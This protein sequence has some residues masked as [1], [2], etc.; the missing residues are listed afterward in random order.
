MAVSKEKAHI[1][2]PTAVPTSV[3]LTQARWAGE[4]VVQP[5]PAV[6]FLMENSTKTHVT[7]EAL[8]PRPMAQFGK[9]NG[10]MT[11]SMDMAV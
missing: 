11:S 1:K 2:V 4:S 6:P 8:S 3:T 7:A 9:E 5:T 10:S